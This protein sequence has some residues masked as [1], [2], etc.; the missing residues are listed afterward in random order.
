MAACWGRST[1]GPRLFT[2][3]TVSKVPESL[4]P[5]QVYNDWIARTGRA[6]D[7]GRAEGGNATSRC[8]NGSDRRRKRRR[9]WQ[10][11]GSRTRSERAH[12]LT[13]GAGAAGVEHRKH[14]ALLKRGHDRGHVYEAGCAYGEDPNPNSSKDS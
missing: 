8:S 6:D 14:T 1:K 7:E 4:P 2:A 3:K 11:A 12:Q 10:R 13:A 9:S 5:L